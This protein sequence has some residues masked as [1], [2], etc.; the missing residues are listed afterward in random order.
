MRALILLAAL[1]S[2]QAQAITLD[3]CVDW[4]WSQTAS[5]VEIRCPSEP[6]PRLV[7]E[8][9]LSAVLGRSST[10]EVIV[11]YGPGSTWKVEA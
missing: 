7:I 10:G 4:T 3:L 2:A 8:G 6:T 1:W 5:G 9:C 11:S